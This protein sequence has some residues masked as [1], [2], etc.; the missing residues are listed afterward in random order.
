[1]TTNRLAS[2][3]GSAVNMCPPDMPR[4]DSDADKAARRRFWVERGNERL[5]EAGIYH[6]HWV[7]IGGFY[8]IEP[9]P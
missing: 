6:L 7:C 9:R 1:M 4:G 2:S 5:A 8:S 3:G